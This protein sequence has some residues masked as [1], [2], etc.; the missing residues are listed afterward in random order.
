MSSIIENDLGYAEP[1]NI[2]VEVTITHQRPKFT[3]TYS[4]IYIGK[5]RDETVSPQNAQVDKHEADWF[6][7]GCED[8]QARQ[9]E[10]AEGDGTS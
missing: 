6:Q 1:L 7:G 3:G 4:D 5:F 10:V 2:S 8:H 9:S